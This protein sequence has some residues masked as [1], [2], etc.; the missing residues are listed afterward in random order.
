M[1][2]CKHKNVIGKHLQN[3][4]MASML[5][6]IKP[7]PDDVDVYLKEN[8][9]LLKIVNRDKSVCVT[10][11]DFIDHTAE[12]IRICKDCKKIVYLPTDFDNCKHE[13][14]KLRYV[15][16]IN[17]Y[18]Y[19]CQDCLCYTEKKLGRWPKLLKSIFH[20]T[21]QKEQPQDLVEVLR[22]Y[23]QAM[24]IPTG[25]KIIEDT[26]KENGFSSCKNQSV[27]EKLEIFR[28]LK[29]IDRE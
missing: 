13:H 7:K 17:D 6:Q 2:R 22:P 28:N 15:E 9:D 19:F 1:R 16:H 11:Q 21:K 26:C 5:E 8:G 12:A 20:P 27:E 4:M 23:F 29:Q 18:R 10:A 3:L 25:R 14:L 24:E